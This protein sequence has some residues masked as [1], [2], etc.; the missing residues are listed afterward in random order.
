MTSKH[1]ENAWGYVLQ[2]GKTVAVTAMDIDPYGANP[3]RLVVILE[4]GRRIEGSAQ[5]VREVSVPIEGHRRPGA[6]VIVTSEIGRMVGSLNDWDPDGKY[7]NLST[8]NL[9]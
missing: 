3:R 6:T 9:N 8:P 5:I 7:D 4:D 2:A 1:T